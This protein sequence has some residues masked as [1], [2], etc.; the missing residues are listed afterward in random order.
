MPYIYWD[1]IA[2]H[3]YIIYVSIRMRYNVTCLVGCDTMSY[4]W[5]GG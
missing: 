5:G 3:I 2:C 1:E 4:V